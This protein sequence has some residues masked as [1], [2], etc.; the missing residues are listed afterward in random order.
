MPPP[1]RDNGNPCLP[2]PCGPNSQCR[3]IGTQAACSC[4]ENFVGRP[5]NCRPECTIN[6]ECSSNLACVH[7]KCID[8]CPGYCGINAIC[9]VITHNPTCSC[10]SGYEG[11]PSV[12]CNL[13][14]PRKININIIYFHI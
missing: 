6:A 3:V 4:L 8:P 7:E 2:S 10:L 13:P 5:P 1:Q 12:Q 11:N 9:R 14:T